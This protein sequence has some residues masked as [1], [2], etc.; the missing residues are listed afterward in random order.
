MAGFP[1]AV[2]QGGQAAH[3]N[4]HAQTDVFRLANVAVGGEA[5]RAPIAGS[6]RR[7]GPC[8]LLQAFRGV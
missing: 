3:G 2:C 5:R 4:V 1:N 6:P 7:S 8:S